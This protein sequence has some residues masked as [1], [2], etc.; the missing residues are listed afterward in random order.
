MAGGVL[1]KVAD[2][3]GG[4]PVDQDVV[5]AHLAA[6]KTQF[7]CETDIVEPLHGSQYGCIPGGDGAVFG[8]RDHQ[9]IEMFAA[10]RRQAKIVKDHPRRAAV[11]KPLGE[12]GIQRGKHFGQQPAVA[13][14]GLQQ[15]ADH[16]QRQEAFFLQTLDRLQPRDM[17]IGVTR[18]VRAG[19]VRFRQQA[20][21]DV[22]SDGFPADA[23]G[24]FKIAH[25][26]S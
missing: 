22:E 17:H 26:H 21:A 2:F 16:S 12:Q 20:F 14:V 25:S 4:Q 6:I 23:T 3:L 9:I 15:G 1:Q 5:Q 24:L 19:L 7:R 18:A 11:F 8:Q 10:V 13:I